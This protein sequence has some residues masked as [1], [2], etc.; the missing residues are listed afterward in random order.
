MPFQVRGLAKETGAG[1]EQEPLD[2]VGHVQFRR[3]PH[4]P[5]C[6]GRSCRALVS[7]GP[8]GEGES[9]ESLVV[10]VSLVLVVIVAVRCYGIACLADTHSHRICLG[11]GGLSWPFVPRS[12]FR[13]PHSN[14][15]VAVRSAFRIPHWNGL[16]PFIPATPPPVIQ[17]DRHNLSYYSKPITAAGRG[18]PRQSCCPVRS[19]TAKGDKVYVTGTLNAQWTNSH[20]KCNG[21]KEQKDI[22]ADQSLSG[23]PANRLFLPGYTRLEGG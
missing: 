3:H 10:V 19:R 23:V 20:R 4:P 18:M 7:P 15:V 2:A 14:V 21:V 12:A 16:L 22:A 9:T 8:Y 13:I 6:Q 5:S 17:L 1:G 11:E